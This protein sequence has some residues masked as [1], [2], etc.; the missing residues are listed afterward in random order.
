[1]SDSTQPKIR[2]QFTD[3]SVEQQKEMILGAAQD[4]NKA[5]RKLMGDSTQQY[6]L[7]N[8][9]TISD[10]MLLWGPSMVAVKVRDE[11]GIYQGSIGR[12]LFERA[13]QPVDIPAIEKQLEQIL[14]DFWQDDNKDLYDSIDEIKAVFGLE[15][16]ETN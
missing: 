6:M 13:F 12:E 4:S 9:V 15:N 14:E 8:S 16:K 5:Q 10:D 7:R 3:L 11:Q 1:M 2:K